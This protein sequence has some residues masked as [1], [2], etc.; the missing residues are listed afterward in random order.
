MLLE[1]ELAGAVEREPVEQRLGE[2]V[3]VVAGDD[4]SPVSR[5][6]QVVVLSQVQ[7]PCS[8][9]TSTTTST[10]TVGGPSASCWAPASGW[11]DGG[12]VVNVPLVTNQQDLHR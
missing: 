7:S 9:S 8:T 5:I 10:T 11:D 2:A 6:A 12:R 3:V 4:R 1:A